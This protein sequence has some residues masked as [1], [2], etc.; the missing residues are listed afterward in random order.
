MSATY[1]SESIRGDE[2]RHSAVNYVTPLLWFCKSIQR[3]AL[4]DLAPEQS[5]WLA[6][7]LEY[8]PFNQLCLQRPEWVDAC[9]SH[10]GPYLRRSSAVGMGLCAAMK[11]RSQEASAGHSSGCCISESGPLVGLSRITL[12][13][14]RD[15]VVT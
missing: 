10:E 13:C 5:Q 15:G 14:R 12:S 11:R 9:L 3:S 4:A 7:S 2:G 1:G 6:A 8:L